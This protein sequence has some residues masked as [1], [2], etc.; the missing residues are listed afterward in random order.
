MPSALTFLQ[1]TDEHLEIFIAEDNPADVVWTEIVLRQLGIQYRL[2]IAEDGDDAL[3][4]ITRSGRYS[5]H[6]KPD[7]I[8]LDISLPRMTGPEILERLGGSFPHPCCVVTGSIVEK[9]AVLRL[10]RF[11][12]DCYIVKPITRDKIIDAMMT[13]DDLKPWVT[14]ILK[15]E[16]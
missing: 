4:M 1:E 16:L 9:E 14:R 3:A 6:P 2:T 15:Q 8:L 5:A 12:A 13:Y 10:F 7:L 11:H